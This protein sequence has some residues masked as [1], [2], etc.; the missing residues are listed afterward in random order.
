VSNKKKIRDLERLLQRTNL[1]ENVR[2]EK[3]EQLKELKGTSRKSKEALRM[4]DMYKK[5]K[6]VEKRKVIRKL[7]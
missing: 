3:L 4:Q 5:V 6:F 1:P 2:N 7:E